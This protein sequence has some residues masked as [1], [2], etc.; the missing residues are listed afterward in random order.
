MCFEVTASA[1]SYFEDFS[2]LYTEEAHYPVTLHAFCDMVQDYIFY[3]VTLH[4]EN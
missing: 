2:V 3:L 4:F 1:I